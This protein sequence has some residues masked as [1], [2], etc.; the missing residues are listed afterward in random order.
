M[1]AQCI[2][3]LI[4][5]QAFGVKIVDSS[6]NM[7]ACLLDMVA[8]AGVIAT[9]RPSRLPQSPG[10]RLGGLRAR[11]GAWRRDSDVGAVD[12]PRRCLA[13]SFAMPVIGVAFTTSRGGAAPYANFRFLHGAPIGDGVLEG[14]HGVG[15]CSSSPLAADHPHQAPE[16]LDRTD[17]PCHV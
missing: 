16:W 17:R 14:D 13:T 9:F 4:R 6:A 1:F 5:C 8:L 15:S 12:R 11:T 7:W 10:T 2:G 3:I